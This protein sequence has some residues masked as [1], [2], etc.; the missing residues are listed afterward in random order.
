MKD[1]VGR[2]GRPPI[3]GPLGCNVIATGDRSPAG[4]AWVK[5][6]ISTLPRPNSM[7]SIPQFRRPKLGWSPDWE[8]R[9]PLGFTSKAVRPRL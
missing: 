5:Q 4:K 3:S 7:G 6:P 8:N 2:A 1:D 9:L